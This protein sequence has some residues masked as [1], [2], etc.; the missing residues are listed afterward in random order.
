MKR[1]DLSS[2]RRNRYFGATFVALAIAI[3][4]IFITS[5]PASAQV[6]SP[7]PVPGQR[8]ADSLRELTNGLAFYALLACMAG[9]CISS[10]LWAIGSRG[11]NAGT[12]LAGKRGLVLCCTAA[13]VV[14]AV[15]VW[16]N[17]LDQTARTPSIDTNNIS[18]NTPPLNP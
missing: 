3:A 5:L 10:A 15:P 11:L 17:Y 8:A 16:I 9:I 12:E 2:A 4:A 6:N 13:F 14:G 1:T 18:N 7:A